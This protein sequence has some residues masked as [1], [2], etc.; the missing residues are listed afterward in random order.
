MSKL[1]IGMPVYN[2]ERFIVEAIE[3]LIAQSFKDWELLISDNASEDKT[4]DICEKLCLK[5]HRIKYFR[6]KINIGAAANFKYVLD[7]ANS[8]YFMWAASDDIWHPDFLA[9]LIDNLDKNKDCGLS[10]CNIISIDTFNREIRS[11]PNFKKFVSDD[12]L[13]SIKSY[14]LDAEILGK[15]NIIYGIYRLGICENAWKASP[16]T[17]QWGSDMCFVLAAIARSKLI[18][19]ERVLFYK[20][21][22]RDSDDVNVVHM[23][24]I[25]NPRYGII[26]IGQS[27][28]YVTSNTNATR[29]TNFFWTTLTITIYRI[30]V[31]LIINIIHKLEVIL[32]I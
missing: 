17:D 31:S 28:Q 20:R 26:P 10:F 23:I 6:Q 18:I 30:F 11:C 2:G 9:A 3:S 12:Q 24:N 32:V 14:L 13:H 1:F 22:I 8:Q 15:A 29:N 25:K 21:L 27:I 5:D 19:D 16:L 7:N 4:Q